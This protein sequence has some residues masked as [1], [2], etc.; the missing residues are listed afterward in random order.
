MGGYPLM[1]DR[2]ARELRLLGITTEDISNEC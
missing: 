1:Q 2:F